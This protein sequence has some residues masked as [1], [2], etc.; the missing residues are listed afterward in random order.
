MPDESDLVVLE[1]LEAAPH[2]VRRLHR[3]EAR[4]VAPIDHCDPR[5][6]R[7]QCGC[8]DSAV[9]AAAHHQDVEVT[10]SDLVNVGTSKA[11]RCSLLRVIKRRVERSDSARCG[12][13]GGQGRR[14]AAVLRVS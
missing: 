2:E 10:I 11:H 14:F 9:D 6:A 7:G 4:E 13:V 8:A 5:A 12:A 3:S 1:V